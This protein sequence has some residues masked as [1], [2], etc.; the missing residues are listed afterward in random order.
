MKEPSPWDFAQVGLSRGSM[1]GMIGQY[2][3]D[4][5]ILVPR[6]DGFSCSW[7]S[8]SGRMSLIRLGKNGIHSRYGGLDPKFI[9][10][11]LVSRDEWLEKL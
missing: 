9:E 8:L 10:R 5:I 4:G 11:A 2:S 6:R 7:L 3:G 1:T